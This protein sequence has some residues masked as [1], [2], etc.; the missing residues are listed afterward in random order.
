MA[1]NLGRTDCYFC[2]AKVVLVEEPHVATTNDVNEHFL[3]LHEGYSYAGMI[4]ANAECSVCGAKY[5]ARVDMSECPGYKD[6]LQWYGKNNKVPFFDLSFRSTFNDEPGP[7]DMP[8]RSNKMSSTTVRVRVSFEVDVKVI[9]T[10]N[11]EE[12]KFYIEENGCPGT[13]V[14]GEKIEQM[15]EDAHKDGCCWACGDANGENKVVSING[16]LV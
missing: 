6:F 3:Q 10:M 14:V 2:N 11:E 12:I 5:L 16:K 8:T 15:I 9:D 4:C 1:R 13:S 7:A